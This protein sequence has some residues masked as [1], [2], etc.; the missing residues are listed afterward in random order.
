MDG[1]VEG[2]GLGDDIGQNNSGGS[3][4][5][6]LQKNLFLDESPL[7]ILSLYVTLPQIEIP[8]SD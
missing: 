7:T 4:W 8:R 1:K 3:R 6:R 2:S 5:Q